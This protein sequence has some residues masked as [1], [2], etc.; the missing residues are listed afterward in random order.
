MEVLYAPNYNIKGETV[1]AFGKFDGIHKGH[2][3]LINVLV[4]EAKKD[5]RISIIYTFINHPK[6]V[7]KNENINLL[8]SNEEKVKKIEELG[9]DIIVFENFDINYANI[10]PEDFVKDILIKKLNVKKVI[11]GSNSTFGKESKGNVELLKLFSKK[12]N[13]E[14]IEVQLLKENGKVI[15]SSE[16]RNKIAFGGGN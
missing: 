4:N 7:L 15:C 5:R 3:K 9:V 13:F 12:Y 11:I 14:V 16:M 1:L 6:T 2:I 10:E 8:T